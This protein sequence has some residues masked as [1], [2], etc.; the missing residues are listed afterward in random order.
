[1][2]SFADILPVTLYVLDAEGQVLAST[3]TSDIP[4]E[5]F[6]QLQRAEEVEDKS[7]SHSTDRP[8]LEKRFPINMQERQ[9]GSVVGISSNFDHQTR[10]C[11]TA[12]TQ[13][14]SQLLSN[15]AYQEYELNSMTTELLNKYEELSLLYELSQDLGVIFDIETICH[16]TLERALEVV[17]AK[18]AF[19]ALMDE[20]GEYLTVMAEHNLKGFVGWNIPFGKGISGRVA[21]MGKQVLLSAREVIPS[22][23]SR[24]RVLYEAVLSVPFLLPA[25]KPTGEDR[26][27]GVLTMAGKPPGDMFTA[28]EAQLATTIATQVTVAIHNSRLMKALRETERMQ[29]EVEIASRIQQ[30]LLPHHPPTLPGVIVAGQCISTATVGGD[31]YDILTDE[32]GRLVLLIADASGHSIGSALMMAMA[33]SILRHEIALGRSLDQVLAN[34]NNAMFNDL[35]EAEM[36]ISLFCARF[37]PNTRQLTFVNGGHNPPLLQQPTNQQIVTLDSEGMILGLVN[38]ATYQA[39]SINLAAG[40]TLVLYTDGVTEARNQAGKQFGEQQLRELL[41]KHY[42][43]SP[44]DL[45]QEIYKAVRQHT[46]SADLQDDVTLLILSLQADA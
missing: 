20:K 19:I 25:E 39:H 1:M 29:Q 43:S 14:V 36:F 22:D 38:N 34:T 46:K 44:E 33:R 17:K 32:A 28:G 10:Q 27:L 16:I 15:Q 5:I 21:A 2:I 8:Y 13:L 40:D 23:T 6:N 42:H 11:L 26:I 37:D 30:S 18:K 12:T 35:V 31:Y 45:C 7:A 3:G 24:R 4:P 41:T 9:L